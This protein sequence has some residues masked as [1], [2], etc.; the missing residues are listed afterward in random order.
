MLERQAPFL[1][2]L[3]GDQD[4][5]V[6]VTGTHFAAPDHR[7]ELRAVADD[8]RIEPGVS[9]RNLTVKRSAGPRWHAA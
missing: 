2:R 3:R 6:V 9:R 8:L 7:Q 1:D 5:E 4:L